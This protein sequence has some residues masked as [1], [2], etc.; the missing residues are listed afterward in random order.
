MCVCVCI[1][2]CLCGVCAW[3]S[4]YMVYIEVCRHAYVGKYMYACV[5][6]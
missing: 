1:N 4:A 3:V 6:V 5:D 2:A